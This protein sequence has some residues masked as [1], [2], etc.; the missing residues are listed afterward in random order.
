MNYI[1]VMCG[2]VDNT[3]LDKPIFVNGWVKKNR[4]LGSLIFMDLY[5][6]SGV[7]QVVIDENNPHFKTVHS[8]PKESVVKVEGTL[9]RRSNVNKELKTGEYE[10]HLENIQI[11]SKAKT[12]P[13]LIENE[14]D[15]LE[16][17]RLRYRYLD[18]RRPLMQQYM[19]NRSKIINICRNFL[20]NYNF[21]EV[22]T[23]Y[24]SK[25]TPEG[26]RD[27]LVP[28]R[29]QKFFALPQS[30]QIYKQ[31]L[32]V[33]GFNAYFQF[34]RCFRDEDLR[35]DRQPEFTQLDMEMSFVSAKDVQ[36]IIENL[37]AHLFKEFFG[38]QLKTPFLRMDYNDAIEYYGCDKPDLRYENK[39]INLTSYFNNTNFKIF[40]SIVDSNK[41]IGGLFL[42][43]II[44][45]NE[46]KGLEKLAKDN[47]AKGLAYLFIEN[48]T[49]TSGSIANV[50]EKEIIE[51]ICKEKNITNGTLFF[52]ADEV[53]TTLKSL[54]AIRREFLNISKAIKMNEEFSFVW[55]VNWPLFE[56]SEEDNR[57]VA[58][59]HPFTSPSLETIDTF[60]KD[61]QNAKGESYDIVLNGYEVGGGS[62][63]IHDFD[64]QT[65][66]FEFLGLSKQ[67]IDEKFGFMINAFSY[68]VPPHGGI[69]LGVERLLM[70]MLKTNSIRD[71]IAFP[72]NS[73]GTDM[74][75]NSPSVVSEE[76][77]KEL[78]LKVEKNG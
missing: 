46:I 45:K 7:V 64:T 32:M 14:T 77:L 58:A 28:T 41:R 49:F 11:Y 76:S 59:H 4:K 33:S 5:D 9:K 15:G 72:K 67:E 44:S 13:F 50:I 74:L 65:R 23:P 73:S 12:P 52:V 8:I 69:A 70:L 54:G 24:L 31:L 6:I 55:I 19:L 2:N 17:L 61:P 66:M 57:Y 30:P 10:I 56:Y 78:K 63:R 71:V 51:Q 47:G 39:I 25:Q 42:E 18:L 62:I 53:E 37:F 1:K 43:E 68:G 26:A 36:T 48:G 16:D 27:Y 60:D 29:S 34:A 75:F 38:I 40:K 3:H 21:I 22:E 20:L 35:I